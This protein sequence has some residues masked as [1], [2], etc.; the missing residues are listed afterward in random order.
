MQKSRGYD[1]V[2]YFS[3]IYFM[4]ILV[5]SRHSITLVVK[6]KGRCNVVATSVSK[7]TGGA[8]LYSLSQSYPCCGMR[9]P[10]SNQSDLIIVMPL[11]GS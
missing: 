5:I 6:A 10:I 11:P 4:M 1:K 2:I 9:C 7:R 8:S 3:T